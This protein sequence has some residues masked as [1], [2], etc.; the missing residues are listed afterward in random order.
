MKLIVFGPTGGTGGQIV[1]QALAAGHS[2]VAIARK[3]EAVSLNHS[4][5]VVVA[6]D[7]LDPAWCGEGIGGAD[8]VLSVLG[9]RAL[10]QPTHIYSDGTAAILA[11]MGKAGVRRFIGVTATPVGPANLKSPFDR[12]VVHPILQRFFGGAYDDMRRMEAVLLASELD[13]TV[14]RPPRLTNRTPTGRYRTAVDRRLARAW[15]VPRSDLAAAMLAVVNDR[16]LI[17]R[18]ITIAT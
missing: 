6:G 9:A 1:R 4:R 13:W 5:L 15:V 10:G 17:R 2:V 16:K 8:A 7:V 11:A 3:P 18:A 12:W 14:F